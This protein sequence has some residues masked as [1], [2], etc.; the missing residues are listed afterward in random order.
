MAKVIEHTYRLKRGTAQRWAEINPILEEGEPGFETDTNRLKIGDG[1][2]PYMALP[3]IASGYFDIDTE[4]E[5]IIDC[6]GVP[7]D[8]I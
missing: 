8:L 1:F 6:G 4:N 3:Y 7:E 5:I 2:S